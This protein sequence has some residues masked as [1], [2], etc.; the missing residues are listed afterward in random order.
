MSE[1]R[2]SGT[3]YCSEW[4][5]S[6][7]NDG[8]NP[9]T[10][11]LHPNNGP[12]GYAFNYI[13][14]AGVYLGNILGA[15]KIFGD[16]KVIIDFQ[17]NIVGNTGQLLFNGVHMKN[18]LAPLGST[19]SF[20]QMQNCIIEN[21]PLCNF[22]SG[23]PNDCFGNVLVGDIKHTN[24]HNLFTLNNSL[25]LVDFDQN[26]TSVQRFSYNY[27]PSGKRFK[28]SGTNLAVVFENC[29]NGL[30]NI[31]GTDYELK[32]LIDGS[33]RPD[34]D[35]S[36]PDIIT[37]FPNVYTQGNFAGNANILDAF[38]K[39]VSPNS[40]LLKRS[41]SN[42][43]IGGVKAGR[44]IPVNTTEQN[45]FITTS[46]IDTSDPTNL[47]IGSG[48]DEGFIDIVLRLNDNVVEIPVL[49]YDGLLAFDS[50]QAGGTAGN[51]NVPDFFPT[52]FS[53]L[54]QVGL[55]PN[56]LTYG[57]RSSRSLSR[58]TSENQWDN[59]NLALGSDVARFYV[60]EWGTKPTI[61]DVLGVTYGNGNPQ[62]IGGSANTIN[63]RWIQVRIRLTNRREQ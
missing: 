38:N 63:A 21:M 6:P 3:H 35:P 30:F 15:K 20:A 9:D 54:S 42:G 59:D 7:S 43:F 41:N 22:R 17:N 46:Q 10:P 12:T 49:H 14:G 25:I 51:N 53:P 58:P 23:D 45:V 52:L 32:K 61:T 29:L 13:L 40:D 37:V 34:A 27:L 50:S 11:Y 26:N 60:Q 48:F 31:G 62:S 39:V 24:N 19:S 18:L 47:K 16:G 55:K 56:R 5:G 8:T 33:S 1:F 4:N 2:L 44:S 57:L 36:I 28:F